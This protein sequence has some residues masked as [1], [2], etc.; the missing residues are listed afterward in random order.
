[1]S[2][3]PLA[4][5]LLGDESHIAVVA[6][7]QAEAAFPGGVGVEIDSQVTARVRVLIEF[8][9]AAAQVDDVTEG[10]VLLHDGEDAI[11]RTPDGELFEIPSVSPVEI[12]VVCHDVSFF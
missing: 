8:T 3:G 2:G 12:I 10:A 7:D 11:V 1:E 4:A 9:Q 6:V 5:R